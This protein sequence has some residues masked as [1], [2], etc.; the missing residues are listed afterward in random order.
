MPSPA[1]GARDEADIPEAEDTAA[2]LR[3]D[4]AKTPDAHGRAMW[5]QHTEAHGIAASLKQGDVSLIPRASGRRRHRVEA[6]ARGDES[7]EVLATFLAVASSKS[8][9][10]SRS[11][12]GG[13]WAEKVRW[14]PARKMM[15]RLLARM[16]S[17]LCAM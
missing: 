15:C 5:S 14:S 10:L 7:A 2:A 6:R 13:G 12:W 9:L 1:A 17:Q 8:A 16:T 4:L 11:A 3:A